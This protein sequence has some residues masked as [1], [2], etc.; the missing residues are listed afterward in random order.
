MLENPLS[1]KLQS[2]AE[3]M[4]MPIEFEVSDIDQVDEDIREAYVEKEGKFVLDPEKHYEIKANAL[5]AKNREVIQKNKTLS[6]QLKTLE[7]VKETAVTDVDKLAQEYQQEIAGLKDQLRERSVWDP[8]KDLAIK[9]GVLP[10]RLDAFLT[11]LRAQGRFDQDEEG[12][13]VYKDKFGTPTAI[14]PE[15]AFEVYLKDEN[16]WA[17]ALPDAK[18]TGAKGGTKSSMTG[19]IIPREVFDAMSAPE[20]DNAIREKARII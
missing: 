11:L 4:F 14:R 13:L 1:G 17:F 2:Q 20:R 7:K 3:E 12:K 9:H 19:R 6:E 10:D 8:V 15:R 5:I 16:K 18:G